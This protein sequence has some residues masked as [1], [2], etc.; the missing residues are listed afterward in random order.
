MCF[1]SEVW[2]EYHRNKTRCLT[3]LTATVIRVSFSCRRNEQGECNML[4][5]FYL[6]GFVDINTCSETTPSSRLLLT[7]R[8]S[9]TYYCYVATQREY[10]DGVFAIWY[11]KTLLRRKWPAI[12]FL[13]NDIRS[14]HHRHTYNVSLSYQPVYG[15][16]AR[17]AMLR[18]FNKTNLGVVVETY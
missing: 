5:T 7:V 8:T 9:V 13:Q 16:V 12:L 3:K 6:Y 18:F 15:Q 11:M 14:L 2:S 10:R 4:N 17:F 1:Q